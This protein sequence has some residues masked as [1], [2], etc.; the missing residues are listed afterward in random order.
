MKDYHK[1]LIIHMVGSEK[2][3]WH[4]FLEKIVFTLNTIEKLDW[5]TLGAKLITNN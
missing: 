4:T 1:Q 3:L 2:K 5:F